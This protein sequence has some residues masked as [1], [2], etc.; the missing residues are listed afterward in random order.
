MGVDP[1]GQERADAA[2]RLRLLRPRPRRAGSAR[3]GERLRPRRRRH[4]LRRD[5][6]KAIA[7]AR[8]GGVHRDL[9]RL[10]LYRRPGT[11]A[12][13]GARRRRLSRP[14]AA[15]PGDTANRRTGRRHL[16][17]QEGAARASAARA[18]RRSRGDRPA[19][20]DLRA[21]RPDGARVALRQACA[22]PQAERGP[23]ERRF[24]PLPHDGRREHRRAGEADCRL[25]NDGCVQLRRSRP[26][27]GARD[28]TRSRSCRRP[29][30]R[31]GAR[32]R[33]GSM[34]GGRP[35]ALVDAEA[36]S[37]RHGEGRERARLPARRDVGG[38][39]A[40]TV[41]MVD[42][43][44]PRPRLARRAHTWRELYCTFGYDAEDE[45]I[46]DAAKA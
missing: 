39:L 6:R 38:R 13:R 27:H 4:P 37:R 15:R 30:V 3:G 1:R 7:R 8:R 42:R 10:G 40:A 19:L 34:R 28:L 21:R 44:D 24:E 32:V 41:P 16:L 43:R 5:S 2:R 22:R 31:R 14:A 36:V 18:G 12:G 25:A 23:R 11:H 35:D 29:R 26:A 9:E 33:P 46:A 45:L 20:R 17:D